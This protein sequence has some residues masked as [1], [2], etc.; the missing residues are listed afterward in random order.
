MHVLVLSV[1]FFKLLIFLEKKFRNTIRVSNSLG[2]F[3]KKSLEI[4]L[5]YQTVWTFLSGL[6]WVQTVCIGYKQVT[7]IATSR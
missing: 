1:I 2:I 7:K 5:E 6:I 4:T 3:L